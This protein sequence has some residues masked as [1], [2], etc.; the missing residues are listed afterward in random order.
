MRKC[1]TLKANQSHRKALALLGVLLLMTAAGAAE[2]RIIVADHETRK[3]IKIAL[4]GT[5]NRRVHAVREA[6]IGAGVSSYRIE[7]GAYGDPQLRTD[8]HVAVLVSSN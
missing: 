5:S 2:R 4:D 7:S 8:R 6:L 3:V 1:L